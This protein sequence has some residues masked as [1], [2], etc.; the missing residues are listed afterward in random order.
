MTEEVIRLTGLCTVDLIALSG[1]LIGRPEEMEAKKLSGKSMKTRQDG[2]LEI[3]CQ[4]I[5][6][7]VFDI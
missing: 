2:N 6:A 7:K 1:A 3:Q 4:K 5:L